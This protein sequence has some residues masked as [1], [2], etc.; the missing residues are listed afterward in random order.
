MDQMIELAKTAGR[1]QAARATL[2]SRL[3]TTRKQE[4]FR[5]HVLKMATPEER[6]I[7]EFARSID[8]DFGVLLEIAARHA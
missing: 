7:A 3:D 1:G 5:A 6:A 2:L 8:T 4:A